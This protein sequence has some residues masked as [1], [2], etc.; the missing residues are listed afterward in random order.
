MWNERWEGKIRVEAFGKGSGSVKTHR[1]RAARAVGETGTFLNLGASLAVWA[2]KLRGPG[3][4]DG[5]AASRDSKRA[6]EHFQSTL[7]DSRR[8]T[9]NPC[10]S[11]DRVFQGGLDHPFEEGDQLLNRRR[12]SHRGDLF[13][14]EAVQQSFDAVRPVRLS[15]QAFESL[16]RVAVC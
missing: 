10:V 13:G 1:E 12:R 9:P 5:R 7:D 3:N 4:D 15:E 6:T 16:F 14:T 11:G 2:R 8:Q